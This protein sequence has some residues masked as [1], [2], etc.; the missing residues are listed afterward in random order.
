LEE[1]VVKFPDGLYCINF[2]IDNADIDIKNRQNPSLTCHY[3]VAAE[4]CSIFASIFANELQWRCKG[5][6]NAVIILV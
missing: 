3:A 2:L 6:A 1:S 4:L 5:L